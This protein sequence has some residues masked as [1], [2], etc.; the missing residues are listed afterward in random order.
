MSTLQER[1]KEAS[2]DAGISQA[3][4]A[5]RVRVTRSAIAHWFS[6]ATRELTGEN[7][8]AASAALG[9]TPTWLAK[10]TGPKTGAAAGLTGGGVAVWDSP[11]DLPDD[12]SR[13]WID[14]W[15]YFCSA[16][17]GGIQW[18]IRQKDALP[19]NSEFFRAIGSKPANCR[20]VMVR[21]DSM[22][23]FLFNRDMAMVD[24]SKTAIRDG[25]VYAIM[26]GDEPLVK[27]VFKKP[28]GSLVLHSYNA[29]YPDK[30]IPLLQME[31]VQIIGEVI[32]RSG[33]GFAAN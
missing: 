1:L 12:D 21:G 4:L 32:Y 7:L 17:D 14:R 33:S 18:E 26:Y 29:K 11:E 28:D 19:F 8:I 2:R 5:R 23:P 3:E 27:Q 13:V 31:Y 22:E 9:V 15:D 20:L 16:G 30:D 6:G 10:G 25:V 24:M